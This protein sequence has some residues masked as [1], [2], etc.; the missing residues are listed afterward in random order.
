[1]KITKRQLRRIIKEEMENINERFTPETLAFK[2]ALEKIEKTLENPGWKT[3]VGIVEVWNEIK[4][5]VDSPPK[6]DSS[7]GAPSHA[8]VTSTLPSGQLVHAKGKK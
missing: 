8:G 3:G 7:G 4:D 6:D 2:S 1:M 5:I